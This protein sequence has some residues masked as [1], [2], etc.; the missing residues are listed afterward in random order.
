[1]WIVLLSRND[2]LL[3]LSAEDSGFFFL[4]H[5]GIIELWLVNK[6][7]V[8]LSYYALNNGFY[9]R[10]IRMFFSMHC[11]CKFVERDR[12]DRYNCMLC[13]RFHRN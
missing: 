7:V 4:F 12:C 13:Y 1:M 9:E 2:I 3:N 11:C 10:F 5:G 6:S 8:S